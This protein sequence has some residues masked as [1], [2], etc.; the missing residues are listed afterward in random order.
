MNSTKTKLNRILEKRKRQEIIENN[1]M[2]AV[3]RVP[4]YERLMTHKL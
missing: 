1:R 3:L 4:A 2:K